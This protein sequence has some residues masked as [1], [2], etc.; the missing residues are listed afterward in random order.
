[1]KKWVLVFLVF[2]LSCG[3][4]FVRKW[5]LQYKVIRLNGQPVSYSV[6]YTT[7]GGKTQTFGPVVDSVWSSEIIEEV[8]SG[9]PLSF[10]VRISN[11]SADLEMQVLRNNAV[12]ENSVLLFPEREKTIETEF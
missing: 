11:G 9:E 12:H 3:P 1:M 10:T 2:V 6:S 4:R 5:D 7:L 8:P